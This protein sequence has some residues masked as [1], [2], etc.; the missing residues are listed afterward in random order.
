MIERS[1]AMKRLFQEDLRALTLLI[2]KRANPYG[3][4]QLDI[5]QR[6]KLDA[7]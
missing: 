4:L 5:H 6:L 3:T 1:N 7:V 2:W